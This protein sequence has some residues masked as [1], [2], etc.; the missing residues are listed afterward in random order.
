LKRNVSLAKDVARRLAREIPDVS[1]SPARAALRG[2]IMT[3][4]DA[5][6]EEARVRL[7]WLIAPYLR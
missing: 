3:A 4:K 1:T 7:E 5:I 6:S 2:A